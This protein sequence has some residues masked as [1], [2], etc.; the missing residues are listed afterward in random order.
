MSIFNDAPTGEV[1][2]WEPHGAAVRWWGLHKYVDRKSSW[3]IFSESLS[4]SLSWMVYNDGAIQDIG[5]HIRKELLIDI[6][7]NLYRRKAIFQHS[8]DGEVLLYQPVEPHVRWYGLY[9]YIDQ[10]IEWH[11]RKELT[12]DINYHVWGESERD[13]GWHIRD[14]ATRSIA[15]NI[16]RHDTSGL[17]WH[18]FSQ[19]S[20]SS[21]WNIFT[22]LLQNFSY[23]IMAES[24]HSF[25]WN[26]KTRL[27]RSIGYNIYTDQ[28]YQFAWEIFA[29]LLTR[30]FEWNI[31]GVAPHP[32]FMTKGGAGLFNFRAKKLVTDRRS[33]AKPFTFHADDLIFTFWPVRR[34]NEEESSVV[35]QVEEIDGVSASPLSIA[36]VTTSDET[37]TDAE[38]LAGYTARAVTTN[39]KSINITF[40]SSSKAVLDRFKSRVINFNYYSRRGVKYGGRT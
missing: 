2:L 8:P 1:L 6:A 12:R 20:R 5:W 31:A 13:I 30:S 10:D 38:I 14:E 34:D 18:I 15:W 33:I 23:R 35:V 16:F 9:G 3:Q 32:V 28:S 39:F 22:D 19:L 7:W 11:I 37:S 24:D 36:D 40:Q 26:I 29:I 4:R 21:A 17:A 25:A 27:S